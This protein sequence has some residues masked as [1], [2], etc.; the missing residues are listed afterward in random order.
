MSK[1]SG[2]AKPASYGWGVVPV[3]AEISGLTFTTSLFPKDAGYVLPIKD[4]VR[5]RANVTVGDRI[6]VTMVVQ[7]R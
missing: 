6:A 3:E 7:A 5:R 4:S 1:M 2:A